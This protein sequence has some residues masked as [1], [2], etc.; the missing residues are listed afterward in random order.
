M[1][2]TDRDDERWYRYNHGTYD[3]C[4]YRPGRCWSPVRLRPPQSCDICDRIWM[5]P[6]HYYTGTKGKNVWNRDQRKAERGH[7]KGLM[8]RARN[9]HVDWDNL[10]I[11]YRRP[12]WD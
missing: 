3:E 9:G 1:A 8:Q 12:Y 7:A 2:H 4:A 10:S 5:P 11:A 6:R